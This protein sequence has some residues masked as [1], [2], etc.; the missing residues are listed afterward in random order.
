M[1]IFVQIASYRDPE[2][3]PTIKDMLK[4]AKYPER[5]RIGICHQYHPADKFNDLT[6]F[7]KDKR[8]R[9]ID[10]IYSKSRGAC[11]AR[12]I[13]QQVYMG[14]DY[15]LT[16]DSHMRFTI[17]WDEILI[18][19]IRFL[20]S[21]GYPKPLLTGY[22]AGYEPAKPFHVKPDESPLQMEFDQ[23]TNEGVVIFKSVVIPNWKKIN[24]PVPARFYSG[25]FSFTLGIF[26]KEVQHDP[27][28]YF[29]GEE[30]SISARAFTH[31]YDLFHPHRNIV[32]HYYTR[33]KSKRQWDDDANWTKKDFESIRR[34]RLLFGMEKS[35]S[36]FNFG[37]YGFGN[38]RTLRD[39]E[40]Y[41]GIL[42]SSR[43][44]QKD[45]IEGKYP[46]NSLCDC[47][48][49]RWIK[50]FFVSNRYCIQ[51]QRK[52]L[53]ETDYDFWVIAFNSEDHKPV[54]RRDADKDELDIIT[55]GTNSTYEIWRELYPFVKPTYWVLWPHSKSKGWCKRLTGKIS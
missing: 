27:A 15:T 37:R 7:K 45:T 23:F 28:Y 47:Q 43:A 55:S 8:F 30:I 54:L 18:N 52:L 2:L 4:K 48:E 39:Y 40:R 12:N 20:Q 17:N 13:S 51:V 9:I 50:S 32:W 36:G 21:Q 35:P 25:G 33:K 53:K 14:E 10:V 46:P 41:A 3:V 34:N 44:V 5:L 24:Y 31:G 26:C 11:W 29:V 1:S 19:M 38:V 22:M 42:F 49:Q 6:S 16:I